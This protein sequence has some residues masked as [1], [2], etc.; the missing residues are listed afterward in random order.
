[1]GFNLENV[2]TKDLLAEIQRRSDCA[3]KKVRRTVF[4]GTL[5]NICI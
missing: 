5:K 4:I 1:M 3:E 2:K